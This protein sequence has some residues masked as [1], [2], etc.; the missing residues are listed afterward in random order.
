MDVETE[1]IIRKNMEKY[2]GDSTVII[3][4]HHLKMV[5]ECQ[6]IF[7][8]DN[9]EIVESGTYCELLEATN[10]KFYSLYKRENKI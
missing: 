10:S 1:K 4:A 3:I 9:R 2:F 8:I 7:V 5:K 6:K